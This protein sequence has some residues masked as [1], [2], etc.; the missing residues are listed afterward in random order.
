MFASYAENSGQDIKTLRFVTP[1]GDRVAP[2]VYETATVGSLDLEDGD[3]ID[4]FVEQVGGGL[5]LL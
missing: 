2:G 5:W 4:V 1:D 3:S